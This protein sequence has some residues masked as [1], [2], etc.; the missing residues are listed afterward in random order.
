MPSHVAA[1]RLSARINA[2]LQEGVALHQEG[3]LAEAEH[4][5]RSILQDDPRHADALHL[6]GLAAHQRGAQNEAAELV[7]RALNWRSNF[8]A[9]FVTLGNIRMAQAR[10]TEA[11]TAYRRALT[12]TPGEPET[13]HNLGGALA[14]AGSI[15]EAVTAYRQALEARP[16]QHAS[17]LALA[18]A[19]ATLGH[20]SSAETELEILVSLAPG[21]VTALGVLGTV[22]LDRGNLDGAAEAYAAAARMAPEDFEANTGL[23]VI[24]LRR[25]LPAAALPHLETA[26]RVNSTS[27]LAASNLGAALRGLDRHAD[28][29]PLLQSAVALDSRHVMA[30]CNLGAV[31]L[32]LGRAAEALDCFDRAV[33]ANPGAAEPHMN[34]ACA[35]CDL[36]RYADAVPAAR[37]A[38]A[39]QPGMPSALSVL[40]RAS[41]ELGLAE[42]AIQVCREA[43]TRQPS[44]SEAHWNLALPLLRTGQYEEGWREFEWRFEAQRRRLRPMP[45]RIPRWQGESLAGRT[46]LV[47]WEQGFGDSIHFARYIP[48]LAD[49]GARVLLQVQTP[50]RRLFQGLQGVAEF[51]DIDASAVRA[52]YQV[53]M[54]S[55][56]HLFGTTLATVPR[57]VPYLH[58]AVPSSLLPVSGGRRRIGLAWSGSPAQANNRF[59]S[60]PLAEL[61]PLLEL[62]GID[63]VSLQVGAPAAELAAVPAAGRLNDITAQ[64]SDFADTAALMGELDLI[65]TIDTS[66][67]HLAGALARPVWLMLS[68]TCCWRYLL[69][70]SD[71]PWYPTA[72]LFRQPSPGDWASVVA[73]IRAALEESAS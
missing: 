32:D 46:L 37:Q 42:Q 18:R 48:L 43:I 30:L 21:D 69:D 64:L 51:V 33:A 31:H 1:E 55:L 5:Y 57:E 9:A 50:L 28:A 2:R 6:L 52:D 15:P 73:T 56:P 14:A 7:R 26:R 16:A 11:A 23:G 17:R 24:A 36:G 62:P 54:M 66:V 19:L 40:G 61:A 39:I 8:P 49:R 59:R 65:V 13:L 58:A 63:W 22:R 67:A 25:G 41:G 38:L 44:N 71:S 35:L 45:T 68:H 29:L 47:Y 53:A 20:L 10:P 12:T 60:I 70:R 72:R 34:R 3:R 27:V 4:L